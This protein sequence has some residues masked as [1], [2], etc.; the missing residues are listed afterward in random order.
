MFGKSLSK[1]LGLDIFEININE[2]DDFIT[3]NNYYTYGGEDQEIK[4]DIMDVNIQN[5]QNVL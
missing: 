1:S 3:F 2:E 5:K 4:T